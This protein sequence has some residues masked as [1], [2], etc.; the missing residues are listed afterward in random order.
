MNTQVKTIVNVKKIFQNVTD[1]TTVLR[2][3][4]LLSFLAIPSESN[5]WIAS[6]VSPLQENVGYG[7][8]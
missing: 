2:T 1:L 8:Y 3:G 6:F 4:F 7:F 5:D